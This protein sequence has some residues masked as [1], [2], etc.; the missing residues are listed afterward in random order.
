MLFL[1]RELIFF[2]IIHNFT[3]DRKYWLL[4][5]PGGSSCDVSGK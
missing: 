5:E 1:P 4:P 2:V 3:F